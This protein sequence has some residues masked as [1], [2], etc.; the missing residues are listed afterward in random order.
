MHCGATI[1]TERGLALASDLPMKGRDEMPQDA[2]SRPK[3]L[4]AGEGEIVRFLG[5]PRVFKV[6][7]SETGGRYLQFETA[8]A[9]GAGAP[10]HW[11]REEDEAFYVL[12]GQYDVLVG[13]RRFT[14]IPGAFVF[15]PHGVVHGFTN[16]GQEHARMLITV[17]PGTQH[18][19]LFRELEALNRQSGAKPDLAF[20]AQLAAKYGWVMGE[21][22][23][24]M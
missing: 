18:E 21:P 22:P 16:T 3:L 15:V 20:V 13:E 8:T 6:T 12:A 5:E 10:P 2:E 24:K 1:H 17:S 7:P 4:E 23:A 11:H 19:D 9:P 14:A